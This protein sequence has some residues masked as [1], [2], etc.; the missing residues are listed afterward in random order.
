MGKSTGYTI[1]DWRA[2]KKYF[3]FTTSDIASAIGL[4]EQSILNA[5]SKGYVK[6]H[7]MPTWAIA[8]IWSWKACLEENVSK[9]AELKRSIIELINK[10]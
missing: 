1:D 9:E 8:A 7:G 4:A 2:F 3:G 10:R 6:K 5:T